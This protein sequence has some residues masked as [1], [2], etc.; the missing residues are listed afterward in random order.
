MAMTPLSAHPL[1]LGISG[2]EFGEPDSSGVNRGEMVMVTKK[3]KAVGPKALLSLGIMLSVVT[4][5][6]LVWGKPAE[7]TDLL[8]EV[9]DQE[10]KQMLRLRAGQ[11]KVLRTPFAIS[12]ISV[13]DPDIADI[14]LISE[15]EIYVNGQSPGV[16]NISIWGKSRFTSATVTVEADVSLLKEK[17]HQVLPKEK[18]AV[19]AAGDSIVLSGEVIGPVAQSTA[20][21]LALPYVGN[22]KEKVVNLLHIGGVQQVLVEVRL[23][24]INRN[25]AERMGVNLWALGKSGNFGVSQINNLGNVS[26]LSRTLASLLKVGPPTGGTTGT[27]S[28]SLL[29]PG[30]G[31]SGAFGTIFKQAL[32]PNLTAMAGFKAGGLLWTMFFDVLKQQGLGRLLAEPNLVTTSGQEASFLAG[33][34]FPIP[35]PQASGGG[36]TITIE[37]KKF[38]V[39]L[40]FTPTVLDDG[41][42]ALKVAPEVSELDTTA[43]V[44]FT[45]GGFFVPG[46]KIRRTSTHVEVKDGET[47]AIAGLLSD[48]H[49]NVV[50]KF[51]VL[52]DIPILG[53]LFRSSSFQKN[54]TELVVMV[55][56]HLVKPMK[57]T[58]ARLPTDAYIEPNDFEFY[59]LGALEGRKKQG[60]PPAST[61][62]PVPEAQLP[63]F[64]Y[65]TVN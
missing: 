39:A 45:S 16:T 26:T 18:I 49:R 42:I 23:A 50:N 11:S 29:G 20:I 43:G 31:E 30:A 10:I 51:P 64:G 1:F 46:L 17:L 28:S 9:K 19:E 27:I 4:L 32:S 48:S 58:A 12:R 34:E 22:K 5:I 54:E 40:V 41:K 33:G 25:V 37:Y 60:Q 14:M 44:A 59:L 3:G 47:F 62:A 13:A 21:S 53:T 55:T 7:G 52:G 65:Q 24:E 36:T 8:Q 2:R 57:A 35:V 6:L 15:K 56:P 38:G 61:P 63:G